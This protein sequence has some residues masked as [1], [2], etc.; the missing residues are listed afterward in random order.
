MIMGVSRHFKKTGIYV[1]Q[2]Q[3][4]GENGKIEK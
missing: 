2:K 3:E 1:L 4:G